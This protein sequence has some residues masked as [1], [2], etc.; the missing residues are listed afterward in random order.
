MWLLFFYDQLLFFLF[1]Q[2]ISIFKFLSV[3]C[4][5]CLC[6]TH[7]SEVLGKGALGPL[8]PKLQMFVSHVWV[9]GVE[10]RSSEG[11]PLCS[12]LLDCDLFFFCLLFEAI[13]LCVAQAVLGLAL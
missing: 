1:K 9:P 10:P 4:P 2:L 3:W 8:E 12:S 6:I 13:F 5:A 7:M 11:Q